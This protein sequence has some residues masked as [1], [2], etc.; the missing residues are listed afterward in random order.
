MSWLRH[1]TYSV[2]PRCHFPLT[3]QP[4]VNILAFGSE[5]GRYNYEACGENKLTS[6]PTFSNG[7]TDLRTAITSTHVDALIAS[8]VS[9]LGFLFWDLCI[10]FD[11]EVAF[12]WSKSIKS[13]VKF[14]FLLTRYIGLASLAGN[15]YIGFPISDSFSS[16][17]TWLILQ[18]SVV[19]GMITLVELTLMLRVYALYNQDPRIGLF[20]LLLSISGTIIAVAGLCITVPE[21]QFGSACMMTYVSDSVTYFSM[22]FIMTQIILLLL[23][24]VKC[25][26][27]LHGSGVR[28]PVIFV[29][30]R[31]GTFSF[32]VLFVTLLTMSLLLSTAHGKF[33]SLI[34]PWFI[35]VYSCAG[36][37][38]VINMQ[39]L[40]RNEYDYSLALVTSEIVIESPYPNT[41]IDPC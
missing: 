15:Q 40:S 39:G 2:C 38:I 27:T 31:D 30:A 25:L 34:H 5:C 20:L 24:V 29:M 8:S 21:A 17:E 10:T 33:V 11:D 4:L 36:C 1:A 26:W 18:A 32:V 12:I 19:Q 41:T 23:T 37:R 6:D 9:A 7:M 16:C 22:V 14:L 13:P 35:A 3:L 28:A